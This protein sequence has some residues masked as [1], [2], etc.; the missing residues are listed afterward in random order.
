MFWSLKWRLVSQSHPKSSWAGRESKGKELA[1]ISNLSKGFKLLFLLRRHGKAE[2]QTQPPLQLVSSAREPARPLD[3]RIPA[4]MPQTEEERKRKEKLVFLFL[5]PGKKNILGESIKDNL[6][7]RGC[8]NRSFPP[9]R[10]PMASHPC[11]LSLSLPSLP[12][13]P[14]TGRA[15]RVL[16]AAGAELSRRGGLQTHHPELHWAPSFSPNFTSVSCVCPHLKEQPRG[17]AG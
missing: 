10:S 14:R 6:K 9:R 7:A 4:K 16:P 3:G 11:P 8:V 17:A 2:R 15:D 5:Y 1:S 13:Q 12:P